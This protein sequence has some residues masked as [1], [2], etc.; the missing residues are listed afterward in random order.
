MQPPGGNTTKPDKTITIMA[1]FGNDPH[2]WIKDASDEDGRMA[3]GN[4][5]RRLQAG[6]L[7]SAGHGCE[8]GLPHRAENE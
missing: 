3:R 8:R 2:A 6:G 4:V 1:D 7:S 5:G